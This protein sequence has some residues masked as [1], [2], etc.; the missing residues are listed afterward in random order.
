MH[1]LLY[2]FL[3]GYVL[4]DTYHHKAQGVLQHLMDKQRLYG[5]S[6][7]NGKAPD[8]IVEYISFTF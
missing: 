4:E 3:A 5:L 6:I 2:G 1:R 7:V 8:S